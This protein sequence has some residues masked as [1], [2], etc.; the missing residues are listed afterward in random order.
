MLTSFLIILA[1]TG[2]EG[3]PG[4]PTLARETARGGA[5][6]GGAIRLLTGGVGLDVVA[7]NRFEGL[8]GARS[9]LPFGLTT[10]GTA[11]VMGGSGGG[12]ALWRA[13]SVPRQW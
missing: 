10:P 2:P 9:P 1:L 7:E 5:I 12:R 13:G 4:S 3:G 8:G 11:A 6:G